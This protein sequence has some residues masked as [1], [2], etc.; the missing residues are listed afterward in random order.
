MSPVALSSSWIG[1][2]CNCLNP[3]SLGVDLMCF[4]VLAVAAS[5]MNSASLELKAVSDRVFDLQTGEHTP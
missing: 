5:A 4:A 3:S 1:V 2:G